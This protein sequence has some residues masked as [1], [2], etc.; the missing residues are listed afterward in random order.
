MSNLERKYIIDLRLKA[1]QV[2]NATL[3]LIRLDKVEHW[4]LYI[5]AQHSAGNPPLQLLSGLPALPPQEV[6]LS[7]RDR[8]T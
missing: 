8:V 6:V 2:L 5:P 7:S 1:P 3:Y 4:K